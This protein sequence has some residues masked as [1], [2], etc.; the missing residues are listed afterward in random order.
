MSG[1]KLLAEMSEQ[2][3]PWYST[4]KSLYKLH[5]KLDLLI[6]KRGG[7]NVTQPNQNPKYMQATDFLHPVIPLTV[8]KHFDW[9]VAFRKYLT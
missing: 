3:C 5:G 8:E 7:G 4:K 6:N 9:A 1:H 2:I